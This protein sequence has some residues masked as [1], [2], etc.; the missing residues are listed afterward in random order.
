VT[1]KLI[2]EETDAPHRCYAIHWY[3]VDEEEGVEQLGA[4]FLSGA[5]R[6]PITWERELPEQ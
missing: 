4:Q 6:R 2:K 5:S 1:L 3:Q